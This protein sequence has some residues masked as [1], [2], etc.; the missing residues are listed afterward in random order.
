M[1]DKVLEEKLKA[2]ILEKD[3]FRI[4]I[5]SELTEEEISKLQ[6]VKKVIKLYQD[7]M[8]FES[9][10]NFKNKCL[11]VA[12]N[13]KIKEYNVLVKFLNKTKFSA[14]ELNKKVNTFLKVEGLNY[15]E[16]A[17]IFY[18]EFKDDLKFRIGI[19]EAKYWNV[20]SQLEKKFSNFTVILESPESIIEISDFLRLCWIFKLP[21][22]ILGDKNK[23]ASYLKPAKNVTKGIEYT[24][25]EIRLL[26]K[27]PRDYIKLGFSKHG[28]MNEVQLREFLMH[29]ENK[30]IALVFGNDK[31]GLSQNARDEMNHMYRLTPET[32]KPLRASHALSYI[33]GIYIGNNI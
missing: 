4:T 29:V 17:Q 1:E 3:K 18:I 16:N 7:W 27:I 22:I 14:G 25:M 9:F 10:N 21:L 30:K 26:N 8:N 24:K 33:L 5:E 19:A 23:N 20:S 28:K 15:S 2:K 32:S 12:K 13:S 6:E 11:E 31:Y